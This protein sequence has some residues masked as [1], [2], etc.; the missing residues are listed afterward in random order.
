MLVWLLVLLL[1]L[2]SIYVA[3]KFVFLSSEKSIIK[4]NQH[5]TF[6]I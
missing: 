5:Y 3:Y 1:V 2:I 6:K 4:H